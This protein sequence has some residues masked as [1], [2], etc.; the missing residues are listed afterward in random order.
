MYRYPRISHLYGGGQRL[1]VVGNQA[2]PW[3]KHTYH[4][5]VANIQTKRF[6]F[7][8]MNKQGALHVNNNR[9][10]YR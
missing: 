2:Q 4:L 9:K 5:Q 8:I 10:K 3:R 7:R 6:F 1:K